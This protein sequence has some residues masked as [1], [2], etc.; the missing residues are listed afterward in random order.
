M[1][2]FKVFLNEDNEFNEDDFD[3]EEMDEKAELI[4]E[5]MEIENNDPLTGKM[6]LDDNAKKLVKTIKEK[7]NNKLENVEIEELKIMK[8]L[9]ILEN[10]KRKYIA[11]NLGIVK[12][13]SAV[14]MEIVQEVGEENEDLF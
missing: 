1:K 4:A 13:V 11:E 2:N 5:I 7:L 12:K 6:G 3:F 8:Q 14:I 9:S 10:Q